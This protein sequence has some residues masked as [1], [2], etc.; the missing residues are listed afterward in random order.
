MQTSKQIG[1]S[2]MRMFESESLN[3]MTPPKAR[4]KSASRG[5][6]CSEF[7]SFDAENSLS[8]EFRS[9]VERDEKKRIECAFNVDSWDGGP[10]ALRLT[11]LLKLRVAHRGVLRSAARHQTVST[12]LIG[13]I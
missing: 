13:Q 5:C 2:Q 3:Q 4:S 6:S 9:A 12:S 7:E 1:A 11:C 10:S 8:E